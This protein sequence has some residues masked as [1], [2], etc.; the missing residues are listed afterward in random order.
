[1]SKI[2]QFEQNINKSRFQGQIIH[3]ED[4]KNHTTMQVGGSARLF[5]K[6]QDE[7]SLVLA[8]NLALESDA[9]FFILGGGSN[10]VARDG[11]YDG[12]VISTEA[13]DFMEVLED[14]LSS[15]EPE[16]SSKVDTV[17]VRCGAG[18]KTAGLV[19]FCDSKAMGGMETFAGLPGTVGGAAFMNARCYGTEISNVLHSARY[20]EFQKNPIN[21]HNFVECK[22]KIYHN[23]SS[24]EDWSYKNSPFSRMNCVIT[25]VTFKVKASDPSMADRIHAECEKYVED[26]RQKGHFKAP[27]A[28]SVFKND[29][30]IGVPSGVLIDHEG[31]KGLAVGGAQVAPWHGNIIINSGSATGTDIRMLVQQVQDRVRTATGFMLE[32]E[33]IFM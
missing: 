20:I 21:S 16:G 11:T 25:E 18:V 6:P 26:R 27:S 7:Q 2:Q 17:L 19:E 28:G 10:V 30:N 5:L 14:S 15:G 1:M 4:L 3:D 22:A 23:D 24:G 29:R 32:P 8:V 33:I 31:L 12:I 13:L 9:E